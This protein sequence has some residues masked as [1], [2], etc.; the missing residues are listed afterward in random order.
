M[1]RNEADLLVDHL[2]ALSALEL[3][4]LPGKLGIRSLKR[5]AEVRSRIVAAI[6]NGRLRASAH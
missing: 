6:K 5:K 3:R 2:M 4:A 1:D